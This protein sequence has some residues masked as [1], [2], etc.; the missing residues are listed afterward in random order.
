MKG[1]ND[2]LSIFFQFKLSKG[3]CEALSSC[4]I[5]CKKI[6]QFEHTEYIY[7]SFYCL[8]L[9]VLAAREK[10]IMWECW[11]LI[12]RL[13][14]LQIRYFNFYII[15]WEAVVKLSDDFNGADLRNV[16]TEAGNYILVSSN[17]ET[18]NNG[19]AYTHILMQVFSPEIQ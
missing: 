3:L 15:D 2:K 11:D 7:A 14:V 16:C 17:I 18:I 5:N 4:I 19:K 12:N 8:I 1:I 10:C 6:N 13:C 9:F